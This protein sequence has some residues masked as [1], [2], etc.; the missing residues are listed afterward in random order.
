M[1]PC[2]TLYHKR[3]SNKDYCTGSKTIRPMIQN[4]DQDIDPHVYDLLIYDQWVK[5]ILFRKNGALSVKIKNKKRI[6]T[7]P[8]HHLQKFQMSV[9]RKVKSKIIKILDNKMK[10]TFTTLGRQNFLNMTQ[11]H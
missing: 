3:Y 5:G 7:P 11:K 9:D 6:L 8:S 4:K 10:K 2:I 1:P